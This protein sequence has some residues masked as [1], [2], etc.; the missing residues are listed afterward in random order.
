MNWLWVGIWA[1]WIGYAAWVAWIWFDERRKPEGEK[2]PPPP[3]PQVV[4]GAVCF[5][6]VLTFARD[7]IHFLTVL[8]F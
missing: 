5:G 3:W 1:L 4:I 2:T 7:P 6:I 8:G